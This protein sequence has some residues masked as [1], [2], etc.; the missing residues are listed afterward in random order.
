MRGLKIATLQL[1]DINQQLEGFIV[2]INLMP[3]SILIRVEVFP[4]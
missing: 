3:I 4:S 2:P 1:T